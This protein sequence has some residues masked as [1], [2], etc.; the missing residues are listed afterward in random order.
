MIMVI[1]PSITFASGTI[2]GDVN[3]DKQINLKDVLALKQYVA[4]YGNDI[5]KIA[6]DINSDGDINEEDMMSMSRILQ[7]GI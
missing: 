3:G 1:I 5:D 6:A 7:D 2:W 4:G